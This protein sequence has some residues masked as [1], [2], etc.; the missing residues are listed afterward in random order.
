[1]ASGPLRPFLAGADSV[2]GGTMVFRLYH[3]A[4]EFRFAHFADAR[5]RSP[6]RRALKRAG[7]LLGVTA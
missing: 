3:R 2:A 4:P 6:V 1:M 7:R 5:S